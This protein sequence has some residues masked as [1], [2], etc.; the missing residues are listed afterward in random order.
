MILTKFVSNALT[1]TV[2]NSPSTA[3]CVSARRGVVATWESAITALQP[4]L[5]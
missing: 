1:S 3:A 2:A 4:P 5:V